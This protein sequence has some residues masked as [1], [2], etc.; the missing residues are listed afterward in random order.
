MYW[1][2]WLAH[3]VLFVSAQQ[4]ILKRYWKEGGQHVVFIYVK[5]S[6][7]VIKSYV[8]R[9]SLSCKFS[10]S[11]PV[12]L[13]QS[14]SVGCF[15]VLLLDDQGELSIYFCLYLSGHQFIW[16]INRWLLADRD[17]LQKMNY[18]TANRLILNQQLFAKFLSL[19]KYPPNR[20][21]KRI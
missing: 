2:L 4:R 17:N 15:L 19:Y 13:D 10:P 16:E 6:I 5:S 14:K 21:I 3:S 9:H 7:R 1:S 11:T 8:G 18:S 20:I 12:I